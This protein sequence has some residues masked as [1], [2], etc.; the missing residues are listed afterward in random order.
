MRVEPNTFILYTEPLKQSTL[1]HKT[2]C[3]LTMINPLQNLVITGKCHCSNNSKQS[4]IRNTSNNPVLNTV[5]RMF[6]AT[7]L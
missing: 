2:T 1:T 4:I 7:N 3:N 6:L 5:F